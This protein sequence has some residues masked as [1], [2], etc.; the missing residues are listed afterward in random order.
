[1]SHTHCVRQKERGTAAR[2]VAPRARARRGG[3]GPG[4]SR[5]VQVAQGS[6][7]KIRGTVH[8]AFFRSVLNV[9]VAEFWF[10]LL[11]TVGTSEARRVRFPP[12]AKWMTVA[13]TPGG[14]KGRE[15][16]RQGEVP[17]RGTQRGGRSLGVPKRTG[18][19]NSH[20][21]KKERKCRLYT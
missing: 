8:S 20:H 4:A 9:F 3:R 12:P 16:P 2:R 17:A 6:P 11:E 10:R 14:I 13:R 21:E 5:G 7:V 19:E 18:P 1:M 15:P